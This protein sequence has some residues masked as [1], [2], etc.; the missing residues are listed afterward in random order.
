MTQAEATMWPALSDASALETSRTMQLWTQIIGKTLLALAP[1]TNHWWHVTLR[2][3]ARGLSTGTIPCGSRGFE[4]ELDLIGHALVMRSSDGA[5]DQFPLKPGPIAEFYARYFEGLRRLG[6]DVTVHPLAVEIP[7]TVMLDRDT[8]FHEYDPDWAH[9]FFLAL[10]QAQR[11]LTEFRSGFVGKVSPVHFF[12]GGFD[13]AVSR[14]SGRAAPQHPGGVPHCP[15]YV[16][17]E[18]YSHEVS[19][20]GFWPGDSRFPEAAFYAYAYPEPAGFSEYRVRPAAA[21]YERT[22]GEFILPYEAVRRSA[23]PDQDVLAFL[24]STYDAAAELGH[25]DRRALERSTDA[26]GADAVVDASVRQG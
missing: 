1:M 15:D 12:W 4:I 24:Q 23:S 10:L 14:F 11:L 7:E 13:L 21:R 16:Q 5:R 3:S 26:S 25:W 6:V 2:V 18:A 19:S 22:L 8:T 17:H 20:A 9:R